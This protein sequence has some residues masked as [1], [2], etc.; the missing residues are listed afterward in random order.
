MHLH[1]HLSANVLLNLLG[2]VSKHVKNYGGRRGGRAIER[3]R[4]TRRTKDD[5]AAVQYA[6]ELVARR[7]VMVDLE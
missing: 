2:K 5:L 3:I 4:E 6:N 1:P 7:L